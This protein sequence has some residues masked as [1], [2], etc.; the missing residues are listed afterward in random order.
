MINEITIQSELF[1]A[2]PGEGD[3]INT[4][5]FGKKLAEFV[6]QIL[7]ESGIQVADI[8]PADCGYELRLDQF[9]FAVYIILG[10]IDGE[11]DLFKIWF[12]PNKEFVR[13][14]FRK[15]PTEETLKP[16]RNIILTAFRKQ[17]GIEVLEA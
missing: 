2:Y 7:V 11:N 14:L 9:S 8:Y 12:E 13:K 5:R 1:P 15:I 3:Q 6:Q 10:N 16:V 17:S 4:G